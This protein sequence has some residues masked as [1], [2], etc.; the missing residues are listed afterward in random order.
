MLEK[1]NEI[2]PVRY[3]AF[4]ASV[5]LLVFTLLGAGVTGLSGWWPVYFYF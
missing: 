3:T 1:L 4:L 5:V 2:Y